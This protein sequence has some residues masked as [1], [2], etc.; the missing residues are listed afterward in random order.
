VIDGATIARFSQLMNDYLTQPG[1]ML[2][3]MK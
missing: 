1:K 3:A 2:M